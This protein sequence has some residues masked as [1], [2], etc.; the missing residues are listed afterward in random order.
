MI[1]IFFITTFLILLSTVG[2]GFFMIRI[3][4]MDKLDYNFGLIGIL[5][6]FFLSIISSY[7]HLIT[8]HNYTHN[9]SIILLGLISFFLK[10]NL[11]NILGTFAYN[12][13]L[14]N[15][16]IQT[17]TGGVVS[18]L[19]THWNYI[20]F[21]KKD[22]N[23][24]FILTMGEDV[25]LINFPLHHLIF[26]QLNFINSIKSSSISAGSMDDNLSLDKFG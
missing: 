9:I 24:L 19:V 20:V 23:N 5:G 3:L 10:I 7:S 18:D 22:L 21:L 13:Y 17:K 6:L 8:S 15:Y 11:S 4:N 14:L 2:Y 1:F 16:D 26:S 12:S 25:N